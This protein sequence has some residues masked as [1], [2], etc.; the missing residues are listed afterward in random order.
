M[1]MAKK[2]DKKEP[3]RTVVYTVEAGRGYTGVNVREKPNE[4]SLVLYSCPN[5]T[6]VKPDNKKAVDGWISVQGGGYVK[7]EYLK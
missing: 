6:M 7:K 4:N 2:A 5:G 1:D 3:E